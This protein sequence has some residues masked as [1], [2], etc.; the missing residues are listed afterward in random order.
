MESD[1][2]QS[3][4]VL[5][6]RRAVGALLS[7]MARAGEAEEIADLALFLASDD[8]SFNTGQEIVADGGMTAVNHWVRAG[9]EA[10]G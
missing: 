2:T 3:D 8:C 9:L 6:W 4:A 1:A 10:L 5:A 7:P